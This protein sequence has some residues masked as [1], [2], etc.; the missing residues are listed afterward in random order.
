VAP[1][2]DGGAGAT[3]DANA[4]NRF[5]G[6]TPSAITGVL[7][8]ESGSARATDSASTSLRGAAT[9]TL[10]PWLATDGVPISSSDA[11][12]DGTSGVLIAAASSTTPSGTDAG[13]ND[14]SGARGT[15]GANPKSATSSDSGSA[16]ISSRLRC[17]TPAAYSVAAGAAAGASSVSGGLA[18]ANNCCPEAGPEEPIDAWKSATAARLS[19][20]SRLDSS[21]IARLAPVVA[22]SP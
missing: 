14:D 1:P 9:G 19:L 22:A 11:L 15:T 13:A 12:R 20:P 17:E 3:G 10:L 7:M 18:A 5:N 2:L 8:R 16:S 6:A 4:D 21:M